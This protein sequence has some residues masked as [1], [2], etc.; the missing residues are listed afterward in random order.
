VRAIKKSASSRCWTSPR[1]AEAASHNL[2]LAQLDSLQRPPCPLLL[3]AVW[4]T[5][6]VIIL[7]ED[8]QGQRAKT[9]DFRF[10]HLADM[11]AA[12]ENVRF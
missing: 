10:W 7:I 1:Y 4:D 12:F 3:G 9:G 2:A 5:P 8:G 6:L 11:D